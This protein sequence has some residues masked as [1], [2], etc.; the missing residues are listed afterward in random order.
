M[1]YRIL[2]RLLEYQNIWQTPPILI[3]NGVL[4]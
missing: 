3:C 1:T 2:F 4:S